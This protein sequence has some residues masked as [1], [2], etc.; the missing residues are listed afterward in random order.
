MLTT[1][2]NLPKFESDI[3]NRI[4]MNDLV[5]YA[6]Y[7]LSQSGKEI[8]TEDIVAACFLL[9]PKRFQLR[10]YPQWPDSEVVSKRWVD[11]RHRGLILGK[12]AT[13]FSLTPNGLKLAEKVSEQLTGKR[14]H[15]TRPGL[16]KVG[17]E[18]RTRA[19]QRSTMNKK[20]RERL[21]NALQELN[22]IADVELGKLTGTGPG[23]GG[24]HKIPFVPP[25]GFGF[26][27]EYAYI[28]TGKAAV[29]ILRANVP[30]KVEA[31]SLV[32]IES[33]NSEVTVLTPQV[34]IDAREDFT[35]IGEAK[36]ELEGRQVGA[37]AVITATV[38]GLK[39]EAMV[40]VISKREPPTE[41][42]PKKDKEHGGLFRDVK[43]D[44]TAEPKQRVRFIAAP[45]SIIVIA[46]KAPSVALYL[47][48]H[49][50]G[51]GTASG[52]VLLAE[53]ITEAVCSEIARRGVTNGVFLTIQGAEADAVLL[54][55]PTERLAAHVELRRQIFDGQQRL[56]LHQAFLHL[57][58]DQRLP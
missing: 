34:R 51:S 49:G 32:T 55:P 16:N 42:K 39:T 15:F 47:D 54:Q 58:L 50:N 30:D 18:K 6:V 33:N 20:L 48:E 43:F 7:Y 40:R 19:E 45:D 3:Y 28:Q 44:P 12:T 27:P 23:P 53:L 37:E 25:S 57:D 38:N 29:I 14:P 21:D 22:S 2:Q 11:C 10:T 31:G 4:A 13:G 24:R 1:D 46:T 52:Q 5:T 36:V 17:V 41:P 9:F 56:G 26:V 8:N 35:G